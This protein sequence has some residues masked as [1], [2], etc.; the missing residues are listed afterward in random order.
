MRY[1]DVTQIVADIAE[2]I[3]CDYTYYQFNRD[4]APEPPY[5]I[6]YYTD[7]D[8]FMADNV[9]YTGIRPLR[10]EFYSDNK[11]FE[12]ENKIENILNTHEIPFERSEIWIEEQRMYEVNYDLEVIING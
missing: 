4:S 3:D 2:A 12:L 10:I 7:S 5:I 9:N 1:T 11:E 6:Y 8:D